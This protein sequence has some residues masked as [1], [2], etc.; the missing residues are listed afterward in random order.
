MGYLPI[1]DH[2]IIGNMRTVALVGTDGAIDWFCHPRFDSP[3]V[4]ASLLDDEKG[5]AFRIW[6]EDQAAP[7]KQ[8]YW[9][10]T[11]I[12]ITR[13]FCE[14]GVVEI[15]DFMPVGDDLD[16]GWHHQIVRRVR[17][18]RGEVWLNADCRPAFDY[19]RAPH[20]VELGQHGAV[21]RAPGLTMS[22]SASVPLKIG[23]R[24]AVQ[25]RFRLRHGE[26]AVF[27]FR[28]GGENHCPRGPDPDEAETLFRWTV[29]YWRK[30]LSRC[31]Y[32]GR[33]RETVHRSAL[34]LKLLTYE[35]T[36]AIVAA[37]TLGLPEE[38]GGVRNWDYRYTW[39]R[40][41]AF[42]IYGFLRIG[43]TQEAD[44]FMS[45]LDRRYHEPPGEDGAP[46]RLLYTVEG[47]TCIDEFELP[48]LAGYRG[49]RP[50]RVGNAAHS[51]FQLD[52]YGE[53]LDAVYLSNKHSRPI[54]YDAWTHL[55]RI[56]D[57]VA[58]SWDLPDHGIWEPRSGMRHN[59][60]SKV[61]CWVALDRALRLAYKRSFPAPREQWYRA[62]DA[63]YEAI[64]R[65]GWSD[66][67][68][69]F[70]AAFGERSLDA[71]AL[72][73]P[74]VFFLGPDDPRMLKTLAAIRR[75]PDQG[76]LVSDGLV[77]RY[78]PEQL[79][80]GLPGRE[81]TFN[82]CSFWLVEALTRAGRADPALLEEAR[83]LFER[84]IAY[85]NH[86]GLYSEETGEHGEA[87]GNFPQAFTHLS[88]ISAAFNLE[89]A[90]G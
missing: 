70:V 86:L 18:V 23:E 51:Q 43:F 8:F 26:H 77:Y 63:I 13:F 90:L 85:G 73:M 45:W 57:Y 67:E 4:F 44:A 33:W 64:F 28:G 24:G 50:V 14:G 55:R 42:T 59:V 40:D 54:S 10:D 22:L 46:L 20:E 75:R 53:L 16:H 36:G 12:L 32:R 83:L 39:M 17:A 6:A 66:E 29:A 3:S 61:M 68:Q 65:R 19:A 52:I 74:L 21:F 78:H 60:N 27:V 80:D 71:S 2:G 9:P 82:M 49:A 5:G 37:P 7:S 31:S 1:H 84:M 69:S 87:L 89:R 58:E 11:N 56:V 72:L 81:G 15:E 76:G 47:E 62:R 30:W 38:P 41:A 35:P 48:H 34:T 88:L 25:A 79:P